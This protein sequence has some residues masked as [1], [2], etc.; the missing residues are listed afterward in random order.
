MFQWLEPISDWD[1]GGRRLGPALP[2]TRTRRLSYVRARRPESWAPSRLGPTDEGATGY[3]ECW[4][5]RSIRGWHQARGVS[6][7]SSDPELSFSCSRPV[8]WDGDGAGARAV[9]APCVE[10]WALCCAFLPMD[11]AVYH[12]PKFCQKLFLW[13]ITIEES[14]DFHAYVLNF[15][16][17]LNEEAF[18]PFLQ[19]RGIPPW[20]R[21]RDTHLHSGA[22]SEERWTRVMRPAIRNVPT[23]YYISYGWIFCTGSLMRR[24]IPAID[25]WNP[26]CSIR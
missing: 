15:L 7:Q 16:F 5:P 9:W 22:A 25:K 18:K 6:P 4:S 19:P 1:R 24:D 14:F 8:R 23:T 26:T 3:S 11:Q 2:C 21:Q 20:Q 10:I 12:T 17:L 13:N